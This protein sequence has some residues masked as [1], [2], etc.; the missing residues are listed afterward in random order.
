M[1]I[2][3]ESTRLVSVRDLMSKTP[4][5]P[6][7]RDVERLIWVSLLW[8]AQV[9]SPALEGAHTSA[10]SVM[11]PVPPEANVTTLSLKQLGIRVEMSPAPAAVAWSNFHEP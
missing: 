3:C 5:P 2:C 9:K 10:P 8:K 4:E 11:V 6:A 7:I 1:V